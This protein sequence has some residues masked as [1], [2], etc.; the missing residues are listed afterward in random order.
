[1]VWCTSGV[2]VAGKITEQL[3]HLR[4]ASSDVGAMHKSDWD[5]RDM[6][7]LAPI[8]FRSDGGLDGEVDDG[9]TAGAGVRGRSG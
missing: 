9:D 2:C 6:V 4:Q 1:V 8:E 7:H 3:K 5:R